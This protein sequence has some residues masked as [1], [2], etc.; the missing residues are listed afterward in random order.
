MLSARIVVKG[1]YCILCI[2]YTIVNAMSTSELGL[3]DGLMNVDRAVG[4]TIRQQLAANSVQA[5]DLAAVLGLSQSATSRK[6]KGETGWTATDLLLAAAF[7]RVEVQDLM[8][9]PDGRGG[10]IPAPFV[11][12]KAKGPV[13]NENQALASVAGAGFEPTTSGL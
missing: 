2:L 10:W 1:C 4:L 6:L 3:R 7:F 12:G 5:K 8:P 13:L 11:P 9:H